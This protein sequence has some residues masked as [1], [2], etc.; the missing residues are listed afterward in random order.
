M[1]ILIHPGAVHVLDFAIRARHSPSFPSPLHVTRHG[2]ITPS[3][4]R[5]NVIVAGTDRAW[6]EDTWGK[7]QIGPVLMG[8][9]KPCSRCQVSEI[10]SIYFVQKEQ[11]F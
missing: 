5:P 7:V 4:F 3:S 11:F 10:A 2:K 9:V 1:R 6:D 8:L